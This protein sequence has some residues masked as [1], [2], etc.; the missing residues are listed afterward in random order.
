MTHVTSK[1]KILF[2]LNK[3]SGNNTIDY[4][5]LIH[6]FFEDK[7]DIPYL[8]FE[9]PALRLKEALKASIRSFGPDIVV[10]VGGDGTIKLVAETVIG[11]TIAIGI[12]PAGSANGMAKELNIPSD[13]IAALDLIL[14]RTARPIHLTR[15]NNKF[16]IHLSDIGFN[17]SLVK[18]FQYTNQRGMLGYL[19]A[20]WSAAWRHS[21]MEAKFI[22]N[23]QTVKRNAVMIIVANAT[24]Y[25]TGITVNPLGK[26]DDQLFEVVII[27][28]ISLSEI[29]KMRFST[30]TFEPRKTEVF[31][32]NSITIQS[33]R[34][35]HFQI[36]GE[37]YGKV[38]E[39][40]AD[41]VPEAIRIIY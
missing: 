20:A 39:L 18:R 25:G 37:Y 38:N 35:V 11:S 5:A 2:A 40:I 33:R 29:L 22:L 3:L 26:L 15:I 32:T 24:S 14:T 10:A 19:K 41:I 9:L 7:K 34:K 36:D 13:P 16:C 30:G 4:A 8:L 31:Q 12:I 17:A 6:A 21:N 27:R 23:N 28:K 1:P